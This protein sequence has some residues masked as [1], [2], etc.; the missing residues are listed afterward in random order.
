[1]EKQLNIQVGQEVV[2][3]INEGS[4][5]AQRHTGT[6]ESYNVDEW[7]YKG[8]VVSVTKKYIT[9]EFEGRKDKFSIDNDYLQYN[10]YE[11]NYKLYLT[12]NE[13]YNDVRE[14]ELRWELK[15][16][17]TNNTKEI[18]LDKLEKILSILS[19]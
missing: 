1:M 14:R 12:V 11:P 4:N 2:I 9:V 17:V 5:E 13:V 18:S 19:E 3:A 7:T 8:M 15:K 16:Y 6:L 10:N